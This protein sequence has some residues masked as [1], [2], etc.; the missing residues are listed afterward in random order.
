MCVKDYVVVPFKSR[1]VV[2]IGKV[3]GSYQFRN[4]L[5]DRV[6][7]A[8]PVVWLRTEVPR[9]TFEEDFITY[10]NLQPTVA[11]VNAKNAEQRVMAIISTGR[12]PGA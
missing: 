3:A 6:K 7:H 10:L 1:R 5:P 8:R 2:A 4:D 12:D 9:V 11:R